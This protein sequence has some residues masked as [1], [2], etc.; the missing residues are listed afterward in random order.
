MTDEFN[1]VQIYDTVTDS[2]IVYTRNE[3]SYGQPIND[4]FTVFLSACDDSF[5]G[6]EIAGFRT[7]AATLLQNQID[8]Q[9]KTCDTL[10]LGEPV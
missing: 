8:T 1:I 5:V 9:A 3:P 6:F 2:L 7:L 4:H 10:D